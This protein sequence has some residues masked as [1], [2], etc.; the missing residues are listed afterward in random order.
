MPAQTDASAETAAL[1]MAIPAGDALPPAD[2]YPDPEDR[3]RIRYWDGQ[4]WTGHVRPLPP[5]PGMAP[6]EVG[7]S[8]GTS[9]DDRPEPSTARHSAPTNDSDTAGHGSP[10]DPRAREPGG[11]DEATA[12]GTVTGTAVATRT[13]DGD[14][15]SE[16][17]RRRTSLGADFFTASRLLVALLAVTAL[18]FLIRAVRSMYAALLLRQLADDPKA[19]VGGQIS[20]LDMFSNVFLTLHFLIG[21]GT[22]VAWLLW[23]FRLATSARVPVA[24]LRHSPEWHVG[25]WFIPF[26]QLLWPVQDVSDLHHAVTDAAPTEADAV[27]AV[28]VTPSPRIPPF[29]ATWWAASVLGLVTFLIALIRLNGATAAADR[30]SAFFLDLG[31]SLITA[32]GAALAGL[33]VHRITTAARR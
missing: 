4:D 23:Q 11:T 17:G 18:G 5:P 29:I 25:G 10:D 27:R 30:S 7:G 32:L 14:T 13:D 28:D 6:P 8:G 1:T 9:A 21:L 15:S 31:A 20:G 22:M 26:A 33:V 16:Q 2:W 19:D 12:A 24:T 3:R